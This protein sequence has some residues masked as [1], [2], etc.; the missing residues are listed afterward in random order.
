MASEEEGI[1]FS[2]VSLSDS[3]DID[4]G[5]DIIQDISDRIKHSAISPK[6]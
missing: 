5:S 3:G 2:E 6:I 4:I 1:V